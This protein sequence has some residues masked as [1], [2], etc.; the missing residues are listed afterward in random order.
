VV[1]ELPTTTGGTNDD[2]TEFVIYKDKGFFVY[3]DG[4]MI[5]FGA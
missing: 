2:N 4:T 1:N 5:C 3:R